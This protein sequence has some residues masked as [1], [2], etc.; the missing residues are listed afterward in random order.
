MMQGLLNAVRSEAE[1]NQGE[2][3][4]VRH[5][6]VS[7]YDPANYC[8]KVMIQPENKETGWLPVSSQWIGN[9]WGMF[10]PP[11]PGDSVDVQFQEDNFEAGYIVGRFFND[12][13]RPLN[14]PSGEFWLVHQTGSFWKLMNDGK[15]LI[16]GQAEIDATAPTIN[17]T[18]TG[19]I[20]ATAGGNITATAS[21]NAM[22]QAGGTATIKAPSI[23]LKNAGA[24]LKKLCTSVFMDLYNS[25]THTDS[26]SGTTSAPNQQAAA[27]THTTNIV[28]AE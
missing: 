5:G 19:N 17:I 8:A 2:R 27:G 28:Q 9:G 15:V 6:V 16:N 23:I 3:A 26:I 14:V 4:S 1:R 12:S 21:G 25:H 13:E 24:A 20:T 22:V 18:A 10:C 11:S 7:S